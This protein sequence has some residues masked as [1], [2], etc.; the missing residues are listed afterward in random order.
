[1]SDAHQQLPYEV[2][3]ADGGRGSPKYVICSILGA[4]SRGGMNHSRRLGSAD[5]RWCGGRYKLDC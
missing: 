3:F 1:M 4:R 2:C 5:L